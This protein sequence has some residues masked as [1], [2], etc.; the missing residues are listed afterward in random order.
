MTN[1]ECS[2]RCPDS[3]G[4]L[5]SATM[6]A[7]R[8]P[9][10]PD[11]DDFDLQPVHPA[12]NPGSKCLCAGLLGGEPC[13]EAFGSIAFLQ[14]EFLLT[15]SENTVEKALS[16]SIHGSLDSPDLND[17]DSAPND[18]DAYETTTWERFAHGPHGCTETGQ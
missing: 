5:R 4:D 13:R 12:T 14:T 16:V 15:Y 7:Q 18:H 2:L 3:G 6:K 8:R 11:A 17:I 1:G 10:P 9:A